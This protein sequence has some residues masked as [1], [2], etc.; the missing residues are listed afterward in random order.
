MKNKVRVSK[1]TTP[2]SRP[3]FNEWCKEFNVSG[4]YNIY[5][6]PKHNL[7]LEYRFDKK[8]LRTADPSL[9]DRIKMLRFVPF[10]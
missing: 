10:W 8:S 9:F 3:N 1:S 7:N 2:K 6:V 4:S 5:E